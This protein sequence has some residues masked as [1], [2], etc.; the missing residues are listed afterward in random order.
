MQSTTFVVWDELKRYAFEYAESDRPLPIDKDCEDSLQAI[1][2]R[3]DVRVT[4]EA[5]D[6]YTGE[7]CAMIEDHRHKRER[8]A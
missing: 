6:F 7:L 4:A 2:D 3:H 1:L 8:T 5:F